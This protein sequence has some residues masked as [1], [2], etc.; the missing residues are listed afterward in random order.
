MEYLLSIV[1]ASAIPGLLY[2][3]T[4]R[5]VYSLP[6]AMVPFA[7]LPVIRKVFTSKDGSVLNDVL[8]ATGNLLLV[9]S[10]IFSGGW[11]L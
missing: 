4:K 8:A 6:A 5:H 7:A 2:L 1:T 3:S 10:L 9:Y 11:L